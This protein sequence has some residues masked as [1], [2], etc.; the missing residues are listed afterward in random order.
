LWKGDWELIDGL[1]FAMSPSANAE[2]QYIQGELLFQIK[3][4]LKSALCKNECNCY[5]DLD[6]VVDEETVL[7]PDISVV[8][9]EK[10]SDFIR[11]APVLVIEILSPSTA[12]NDRIVKKE[13][14]ESQGVKFFLIADPEKK[15][16]EVFELIEGKYQVVEKSSFAMDKN[17]E[18]SLHFSEIWE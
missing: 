12:Y 6:W 14:Y 1:P 3:D 10:V 2:H 5:T 16:M 13:I 11:R 9:G 17:C 18:L 7:R 8:C 15:N 4:K